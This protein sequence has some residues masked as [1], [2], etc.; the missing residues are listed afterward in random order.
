LGLKKWDGKSIGPYQTM[1]IF[2]KRGSGKSFM[3]RHLLEINKDKYPVVIVVCP[4]ERNNGD[5]K[6]II[7]GIFIFDD[8]NEDTLQ[9]IEL[10][11]KRQDM[12]GKKLPK[13]MKP[14]DMGVL[15]ILDDC[16]ADKKMVNNKTIIDIYLNGR[17][18]KIGLWVVVQHINSLSTTIRGNIDL[19]MLLR[20]NDKKMQTR[21][22]D[23]L[24]IDKTKHEWS[25]ILKIYTADRSAIIA[26]TATGGVEIQDFLFWYKAKATDPNFKM[27][28]HQWDFHEKHYIEESTD[29]CGTDWDDIAKDPTKCLELPAPA[30]KK[31][32]AAAKKEEKIKGYKFCL[33]LD[34]NGKSVEE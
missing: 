9:Q 30:P 25:D 18:K 5:Y 12:L 27:N 4:T 22:Q 33:K 26:N 23:F 10:I 24:G 20:C 14:E 16:M 29:D 31:T 2:A 17:H 21:F 1:A 6:K 13:G 11:K 7:P 3:I 15:I 32:K 34:E 19:V 28:P 8:L